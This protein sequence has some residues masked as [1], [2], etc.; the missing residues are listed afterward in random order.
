MELSQAQRAE[1]LWVRDH[2]RDPDLR[3]RASAIL[4]VAEGHTLTEVGQ[5]LLNR[6][7]SDESIGRWI[8][9]YQQEGIAGLHI[10]T[11]R[12]R[13]PVFPPR[14]GVEHDLAVA[15]VQSVLNRSPLLYGQSR[16]RWSLAALKEAID[17][18]ASLSLSGV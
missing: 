1:L 5:S 18:M 3:L 15:H 4:K 12:G 17:W 14:L 13:K 16:S 11:G 9:R 2:D 6:P 7:V 8:T 10:R